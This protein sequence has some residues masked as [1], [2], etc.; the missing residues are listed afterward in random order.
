MYCVPGSVGFG[1]KKRKG[2]SVCCVVKVVLKKLIYLRKKYII[3]K[4]GSGFHNKSI[5]PHQ[6]ISEQVLVHNV[7]YFFFP[8]IFS[9]YVNR[10]STCIA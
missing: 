5:D 2:E 8:Y 10:T 6:H 9:K 7:S 3:C 1:R 4:N